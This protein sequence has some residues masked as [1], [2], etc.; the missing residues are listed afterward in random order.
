MQK[1]AVDFKN[2][3]FILIVLVLILILNGGGYLQGPKNAAWSLLAPVASRF[4]SSSNVVSDFFYTVNKIASFKTENEKLQ[5]ENRN[6]NY[7]L[8]QLQEVKRE[9]GLLKQQLKFKDNLCA[10][11]DCIDF[12][13]GKIL[14]R[15]PEGYGEYITINLGSREG[16]EVNQAV[17]T[18]G[19]VLIG[20]IVETFDD[21]SRVM[22]IISPESSLNCLAQTTRANGLVR[23]K[24]GTGAMLEMIDQ[25]EELGQGDLVITSGLEAGIPSGLLVGKIRGIEQSPNTVFK[26]ADLELFAD[27]SHI[28]EIFLVKPHAG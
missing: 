21:Y 25:S 28:E 5:T 7:E 27:F 8:A 16:A 18:A 3:I 17:T 6:L 20:K 12:S 4:Q 22:L 2:F 24:Y 1:S 13:A 23:G 10:G 19:G 26:S 9:N 14:S 11:S 15:S